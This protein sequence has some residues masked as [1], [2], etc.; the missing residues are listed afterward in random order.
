MRKKLSFYFLILLSAL[1]FLTANS[2][3]STYESSARILLYK[4]IEIG[5]L[6]NAKILISDTDINYQDQLGYT[7]LY[8]AVFYDRL[9]FVQYFFE[10]GANVNISDI[11]GLAPLHVAALENLPV[12]IK[13]LKDKGC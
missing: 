7:L 10:L 11:E 6:E 1:F 3:F 2:A 8:K 5:D 4:T 9:N 12:M 13:T